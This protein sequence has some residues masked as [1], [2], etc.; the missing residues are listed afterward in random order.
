M[1]RRL[2]P[3]PREPPNT[4]FDCPISIACYE[5]GCRLTPLGAS[6]LQPGPSWGPTGSRKNQSCKN[7]PQSCQS[8]KWMFC[9]ARIT[10]GGGRGTFR[11][12]QCNEQNMMKCSHK[13][14]SFWGA[15]RL[16]KLEGVKTVATDYDVPPFFLWAPE[17][18]QE[19]G[20]GCFDNWGELPKQ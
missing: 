17:N 8:R 13:P 11:V 16:L 4:P 10:L 14:S 19:S 5:T 15:W 2:L 18:E 7:A 12:A 20:G 6:G 3:T 9:Y 1:L